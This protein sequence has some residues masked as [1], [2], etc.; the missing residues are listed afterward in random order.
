MLQ[1][2]R[3]GMRGAVLTAI[4][5]AGMI[6]SGSAGAV[7]LVFGKLFAAAVLF[8]LTLG[9]FLR[10][11]GRRKPARPA[12]PATP[13]RA[14]LACAVL[15]I[16]EVTLLVESTNLPVRAWEAGFEKHNWALVAAALVVLYVVQLPLCRAMFTRA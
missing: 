15:A 11:A 13:L 7:A 8:A 2:L 4:D 10:I 3:Q 16:A 5:A 9:L 12:P 6:G 14:R 1:K